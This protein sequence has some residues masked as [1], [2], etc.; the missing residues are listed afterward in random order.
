MIQVLIASWNVINQLMEIGKVKEEGNRVWGLISGLDR[1]TRNRKTEKHE[2]FAEGDCIAFDDVDVYTPTG[3]L[4]VKNLTFEVDSDNDSLLLT[5]HNGAGKSSIFRCLAGLWKI[6][7]G[8]IT[9]PKAKAEGSSLAGD[10]YYL[11]QKPYNVIGTLVDQLTYPKHAEDQKQLGREQVRKVLSYVELEYLVDREGAFE[12]D[13]NWEDELSL[14]EMCS[15][16][17]L[18][19]CSNMRIHAE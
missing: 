19:I 4:L 11:P 16:L 13:I 8:K 18:R 15:W 9:K 5:G 10:V 17:K 7:K 3:N 12:Q 6:P 14:G 2:N 1:L